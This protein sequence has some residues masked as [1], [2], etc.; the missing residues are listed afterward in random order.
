M[1]NGNGVNPETGEVAAPTLECGPAMAALV[2]KIVAA[3]KDMEHI[4]KTGYNNFH[5]YKYLT[6]EDTVTVVRR[7]LLNQGVF[8][9]RSA[10]MMRSYEMRTSEDGSKVGTYVTLDLEFTLTDGSAR[11]VLPATAEARDTSDKATQKAETSALKYAL[12]QNF[13]LQGNED[14]LDTGEGNP[15]NA[16]QQQIRGRTVRENGPPSGTVQRKAPEGAAGRVQETKPQAGSSPAPLAPK[17]TA[18]GTAQ[19]KPAQTQQN[20]VHAWVDSG[21]AEAPHCKFCGIFKPD[22]KAPQAPVQTPAQPQAAPS[23]PAPPPT[24]EKAVSGA[25]GAIVS[26]GD[27]K[28]LR[29]W[30]ETKKQSEKAVISYL[31]NTT[32]KAAAKLARLE[33][34]TS[35]EYKLLAGT[36]RMPS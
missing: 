7:A 6:V 9:Y 23:A 30:M 29:D 1:Q 2:E 33:E 16:P 18:S 13:L 26:A 17:S 15:D 12:F 14:D 32:R 5:K 3:C 20:H 4:E 24:Q 11:I 21:V 27:L 28:K 25:S 10:C 34:M 19:V 8:M 36:M 22:W 35:E 31:N